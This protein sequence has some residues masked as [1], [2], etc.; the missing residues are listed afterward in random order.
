[1]YLKTK[2]LFPLFSEKT[3]KL[4]NMSLHMLEKNSVPLIANQ[5]VELKRLSKLIIIFYHQV[6]NFCLGWWSALR[7]YFQCTSLDYYCTQTLIHLCLQPWRSQK[8]LPS[9]KAVL[10]YSA[11]SL[12]DFPNQF[13]EDMS[14]RVLLVTKHFR[15]KASIL[16]GNMNFGKYSQ[17]LINYCYR[18]VSIL[19]LESQK[20]M[21]IKFVNLNIYSTSILS[22][23][24]N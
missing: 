1:M 4:I 17:L 18:Y 3:L 14:V 19:D 5:I 13:R 22:L 23:A 8:I 7:S 24:E 9:H 6:N 21:N 20:R 10:V 11:Y 2:C 12:K 16:K 15:V